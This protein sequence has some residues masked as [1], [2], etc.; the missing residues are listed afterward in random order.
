MRH[1]R[2]TSAANSFAASEEPG[3]YFANQRYGN[4]WIPPFPPSPSLNA[5]IG[6][7]PF[8]RSRIER[9]LAERGFKGAIVAVDFYQRTSV[10][11]VARELNGRP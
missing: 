7:E 6:R 10:V 8:L 3:W 2:G 11:D 5:G 9:C 4:Y 1:G